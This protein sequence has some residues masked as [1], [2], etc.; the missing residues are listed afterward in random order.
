MVG[1]AGALGRRRHAVCEPDGLAGEGMEPAGEREADDV[2][3]A[4][5][6]RELDESAQAED[7]AAW[8]GVEDRYVDPE[9]RDA[10]PGHRELARDGVRRELLRP[11]AAV[12][13]RAIVLP[14]RHGDGV[15]VAVDEDVIRLWSFEAGHAVGE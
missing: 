1:A 4:R 5:R 6:T 8:R 2:L 7:R 15:R 9:G 10:E 13:R 11:D 3:H 14:E 12:L